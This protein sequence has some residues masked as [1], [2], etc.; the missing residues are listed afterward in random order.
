MATP[1]ESGQI[2]DRIASELAALGTPE[3]AEGGK[4]YLKSDLDFY[5]VTVP[6]IK[7]TCKEVSAGI[8]AL[9]HDTLVDLVGRLWQKRIFELRAAAV[10]LLELHPQLLGPA[11]VPLVERLIRES[12]TWALVDNLAAGVAG[13]LVAARPELGTTLDRW[14]T[15]EEFWVRRSAMLALLKPLR[16]G[17]GDFDRFAGY[18]DAML[19]E[20]EF[21]IR[22]AIGW[23]LRD[24]SRRR[25]ELVFDWIATRT[26]RASGVTM[27]EVTRRLPEPMAAELMAA[28]KAKRPA[29]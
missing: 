11:D 4:R 8:A 2:A 13:R 6:N 27:R 25:P 22:K 24:T 21:F 5:G 26:H 20:K 15:D 29:R 17:H 10:E 7:R 23:V 3:R 28:Y 14:A 1:A 16:A 18:A 12:G 9:D 19:D